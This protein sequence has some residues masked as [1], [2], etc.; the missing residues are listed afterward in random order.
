MAQR[1][2]TGMRAK[3]NHLAEELRNSRKESLDHQR[4]IVKMSGAVAL[5]DA[6]RKKALDALSEAAS[7]LHATRDAILQVLARLGTPLD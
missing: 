2:P 6:E 1:R 7:V 3:L 4:T 5:A